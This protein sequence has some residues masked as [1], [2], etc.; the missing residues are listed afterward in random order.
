MH[1]PY[2]SRTPGI[3]QVCTNA[4]EDYPIA[5]PSGATASGAAR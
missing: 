2:A 1:L 4:N 5:A 3:Y